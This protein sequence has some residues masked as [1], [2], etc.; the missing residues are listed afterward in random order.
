M[1]SAEIFF[2]TLFCR[3]DDTVE[4]Q[5]MN[6]EISTD[7]LLE[8]KERKLKNLYE[9]FCYLNHLTEKKLTDKSVQSILDFYGYHFLPDQSSSHVFLKIREKAKP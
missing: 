3:A 9:K 2:S 4:N 6:E 1:N 7:E 5:L 8:I